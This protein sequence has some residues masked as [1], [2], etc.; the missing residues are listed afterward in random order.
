MAGS[1]GRRGLPGS[2]DRTG[3]ARAVRT[4]VPGGCGSYGNLV[5]HRY[6]GFRP[7]AEPGTVKGHGSLS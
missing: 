7:P 2:P 4:A 5:E 6:E 3:T 1:G